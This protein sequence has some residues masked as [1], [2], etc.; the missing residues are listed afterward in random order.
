MEETL[1]NQMIHL[2]Y[3]S[4]PLSL[5]SEIVNS[6]AMTTETEQYPHEDQLVT[7]TISDECSNCQWQQPTQSSG[8]Q[9]HFLG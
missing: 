4:Q 5:A 8:I 7:I 3:V 6:V 1:N 2:A 9:N